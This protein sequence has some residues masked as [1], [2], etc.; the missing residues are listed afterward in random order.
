MRSSCD[1]AQ[2][3]N[4][5]RASRRPYAVRD[6]SPSARL[7]KQRPY[8]ARTGATCPGGPK[9]VAEGAEAAELIP[10]ASPRIVGR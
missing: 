6:S 9:Q 4:L 2:K 5:A 8:R 7:Y 1:V 3:T 10:R